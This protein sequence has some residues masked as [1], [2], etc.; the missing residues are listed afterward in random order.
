MASKGRLE[1]AEAGSLSVLRAAALIAA[2]VGAAGSV[3]LMVH[4]GHRTNSP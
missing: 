2:L 4:A 3:G 1:K